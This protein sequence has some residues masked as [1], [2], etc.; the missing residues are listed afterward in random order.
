VLAVTLCVES[1]ETST[2]QN[3]RLHSGAWLNVAGEL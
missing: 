3:Q 2:V 1:R